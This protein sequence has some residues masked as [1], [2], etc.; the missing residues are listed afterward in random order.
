MEL[1]VTIT[2]TAVQAGVNLENSVP[3][4]EEVF[5]TLT[6]LVTSG[7]LSRD[8]ITEMARPLFLTRLMQGEFNPVEMDPY[9]YLEPEKSLHLR[10]IWRPQRSLYS[11]Q[12]ILNKDHRKPDIATTARTIVLENRGQFWPLKNNFSDSRKL[13]RRIAAVGPF[14]TS[15]AELYEQNRPATAHDIEVPLSKDIFQQHT[16]DS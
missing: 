2:M 1:L 14:A 7:K 9:R 12:I 10:T 16:H 6:H 8:Q 5:S 4:A 11:Q 15:V 13:F 3:T